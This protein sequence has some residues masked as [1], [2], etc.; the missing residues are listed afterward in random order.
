M[1]YSF[2]HVIHCPKGEPHQV[3]SFANFCKVNTNFRIYKQKQKHFGKNIRNRLRLLGYFIKFAEIEH[4][5]A[6][7]KETEQALQQIERAI[8]KVADKFPSTAEA[9]LMTDIHFRVN[10]E[11][12]ELV[13]FDDNDKEITRTVIEPW[14]A[15]TDDDFYDSVTSSIRK[16][17]ANRKE[18]IEEMSVIKPFSFVLEDEDKESVAELYIVDGDTV[19]IDPEMM[20]DL[21]KDLDDFLRHLLDKDC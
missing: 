14:I 9:T 4:N 20:P 10:Q 18:V 19:I 3:F 2:C 15:N 12:G 6:S 8:G 5:K 11:T 1:T 7:M 17:L 13:A 21:D 16:C